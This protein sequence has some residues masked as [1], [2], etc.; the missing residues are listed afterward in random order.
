[1]LGYVSVMKYSIAFASDEGRKH[2]L[3]PLLSPPPL[4]FPLMAGA[5][6]GSSSGDIIMSH[7]TRVLPSISSQININPS[8][9]PHT[10]T[11]FVSTLLLIN[12]DARKSSKKSI[13]RLI[14]MYVNDHTLV[15]SISFFPRRSVSAASRFKPPLKT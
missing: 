1:M 6:R 5:V 13:Y 3:R 9:I 15:T 7:F 4:P 12:T 14:W 8:S 10:T 2:I 11:P